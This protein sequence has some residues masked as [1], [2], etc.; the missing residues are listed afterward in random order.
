[1]KTSKF[2][3]LATQDWLKAFWMFLISTVVSIVGDALLQAFTS[4]SYSFDAIHWKQ[5]G[6][7]IL[8]AVITYI[9]KNLLTNSDDKFLK[10][11]K[12]PI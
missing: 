12:E 9:Q 11:D 1:M 3:S 5:I 7:A 4:G 2:L 6:A 10:K 8:V